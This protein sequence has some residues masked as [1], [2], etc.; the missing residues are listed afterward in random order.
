MGFFFY[1]D[2]VAIPPR[3]SSI[4]TFFENSTKV[5]E[6]FSLKRYERKLRVSTINFCIIDY[7]DMYVNWKLNWKWYA[8]QDLF[9]LSFIMIFSFQ[10][11]TILCTKF[12]IF[13]DV[14]RHNLPAGVDFELKSVSEW[15]L[16]S[17]MFVIPVCLLSAI[18][19]YWYL[20]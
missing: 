18:V 5:K 1:F 12:T 13:L 11:D 9:H 3:T 7:N 15:S 8:I 2:R 17:W 4:K 14:L 6:N 19:S 20:L 10:F 16:S